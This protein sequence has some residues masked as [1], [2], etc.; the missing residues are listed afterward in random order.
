MMKMK[1]KMKIEKWMHVTIYFDDFIH[2][3]GMILLFLN[4]TLVSMIDKDFLFEFAYMQGKGGF[5]SGTMSY[6]I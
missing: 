3:K 1:M 2:Q 6:K 4:E 5:I